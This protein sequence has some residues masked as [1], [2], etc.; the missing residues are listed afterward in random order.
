MITLEGPYLALV[1]RN[2]LL[3]LA[4]LRTCTRE[5]NYDRHSGLVM[6]EGL[7]V[8]NPRNLPKRNEQLFLDRLGG[9][10][11]LAEIVHEAPSLPAAKAYLKE[12]STL[13]GRAPLA[14]SGFGM[15]HRLWADAQRDIVQ[16]LNGK[17]A[18]PKE[19]VCA[20]GRAF[21]ENVIRKGEAWW[22]VFDGSGYLIAR[23]R[24]IQNLR[25]YALRDHRKPFRDAHMGM[26]P[27]KLAQMLI[28]LSG[29]PITETIADPFCGS[30]TVVHEAAIMGY[31]AFGSDIEKDRVA[32]AQENRAF[33]SEK[34]RFD[35]AAV[36][37]T[38]GDARFIEI[39]KG[40]VIVTEGFLGQ[41]MAAC[42]APMTAQKEGDRVLGL[43]RGVFANAAKCGVPVISACVP[44]WQLSSGKTHGI[45]QKWLAL[46][47]TAGYT[48]RALFGKDAYTTYARPDAVVHRDVV[49]LHSRVAQW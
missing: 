22:I 10:S 19:A 47:E 49:V 48:P 7:S 3:S 40:A 26:L 35:S 4:E 9:V 6:L 43:W 25:N 12:H 14:L 36:K 29:A 44:R 39:P 18:H 41:P 28:T 8:M 5:V 27:P 45:T 17:W 13:E 21:R 33:L 23:V 42:P 2:V 31:S 1:G 32:G 46:A 34:F 15:P 16:A 38:T 37:Y 24:A 30:G 20:S 11:Q